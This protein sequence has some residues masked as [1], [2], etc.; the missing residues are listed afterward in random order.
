[1]SKFRKGDQVR[2]ISKSIYGD[3]QSSNVYE[4]SVNGIGWITEVGSEG[5]NTYTVH[6][7]QSGP[8]G[9]FFTEADL[10]P[11]NYGETI[12]K[13]RTFKL[14]KE[15][16]ELTKGALVQEKCDDGDQDY[17]VLD[18]SF[19]KYEDEHGRKTVTYPRKAV[20]DEPNYFVEVF[21][22]EP[23]Y[24]TQDELDRFEA[25]KTTKAGKKSSARP[26][27]TEA[28]TAKKRAHRAKKVVDVETFVRV[29]N[30]SRNSTSVA[31]K[32][33]ITVGNVYNRASLARKQGFKLKT[34][35]RPNTKV[36]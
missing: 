15:L 29:Y 7:L 2:M 31:R 12:M 25:F 16:P 11:I 4:R 22:V 30:S 19:I 24:M 10:Q 5:P 8:G 36:A 27:K 14:T 28:P 18:Q 13:R 20:E 1:M 17:T 35:K 32:L 26:V 21:A 33:G 3:L 23:A 9:D 34:M 6:E